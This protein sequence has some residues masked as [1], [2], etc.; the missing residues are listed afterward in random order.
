MQTNTPA[1]EPRSHVG[2]AG[3]GAPTVEHAMSF[4]AIGTR[5]DID[6]DHALGRD[7]QER[8][9]AVIDGFDR[10][11]SRFRPDSLVTRIGR[12]EQGGTFE[13]PPEDVLLLDLYDQLVAATDGALDP[14]VGRRLELLG[15]DARYTLRPA[16]EQELS[17]QL[18]AQPSWFADVER[19]GTTLRTRRPVVIDVG[20]AGKGYLVDRVADV[21]LDAGVPRFTVDAGGDLVQHG[22]PGL[23]VGLEDPADPRRVLGVATLH[24][25]ALCA[26]AT[27]RRVWGEDRH[28][29]LDARTGQPVRD[30]VATW[31]VADSAAVADGVATALFV[32][33]PERLS[34][35]DA[36]L[37]RL[38]SDGRVQRSPDAAVEL[39]TTAAPA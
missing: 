7:L 2:A 16:T 11:W 5:W 23:R 32:T 22:R 10:T 28:H 36:Q 27:N 34:A 1:G 8:V 33:G 31:A 37:V 19:T 29:I 20:A 35:F 15:Y 14:L 6:T 17:G 18:A 39:F 25:P 9:R 38:L 12:S 26:S 30:V 4:D 3:R 13:V 24:R 21:L